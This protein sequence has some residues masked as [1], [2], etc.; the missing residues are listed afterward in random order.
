MILRKVSRFVGSAVDLNI[1]AIN[2]IYEKKMCAMFFILF[3]IP[4]FY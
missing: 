1:I 2:Y 3:R 4:D